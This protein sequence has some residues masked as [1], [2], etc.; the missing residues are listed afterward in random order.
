[1]HGFVLAC[2][3]A[4]AVTPALMAIT[5]AVSLCEIQ[6]ALADDTVLPERIEKY[7]QK[8][9]RLTKEAV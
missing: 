1:M 3:N 7:E 2:K 4:K 6:H 8:I 5:V 9:E